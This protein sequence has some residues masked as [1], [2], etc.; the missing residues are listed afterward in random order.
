MAPDTV[1]RL[2]PLPRLPRL[3]LLALLALLVPFG[4]SRARAQAP[5]DTVLLGIWGSDDSYGPRA[6]GTLTVAH[7][8]AGWRA[9]IAG[10]AATPRVERDSTWIT[11]P[12]S[13][14]AF[15]GRIGPG[16]GAL[17]GLW[18]QPAGPVYDQAYASPLTLARAGGGLW[19]GPVTPL[20]QRFSLTLLVTRQA[21]GTLLGSFHNPDANS[22]GGAAAFRLTHDG[23]TVR[24]SDTAHARDGGPPALVASYDSAHRQLVL[25]WPDIGR[26]I[27]LTRRGAGDAVG[28][29]P[30]TPSLAASGYRAPLAL[31]DGWPVARGRDVGLDEGRLASLVQQIAHG[32]P[33]LDTTSL[34]HSVLVE[35]H[36]TLVLEEY[37]FGFD[38]D[39]THD[40]RSAGKTFASVLVGAARLHGVRVG[41]ETPVYPTFRSDGPVANADPRK[42]RI[43]LAQLLTHSTGLA[44]DDNGEPQP[45]NEDQMQG[46]RAQPDW[47]RY[48]LDLPMRHDPGTTYAYCSGTMNLVGGVVANLTG[49]WLPDLFDRWVAQPLGIRQ[50]HLNLMPTG[51][52]YFGGG[53]Q[54]R[55]RDFLKLG[56]V[57]RD[58]GT[59]RGR[60]IVTRGW[61]DTSTARQI[62]TSQGGADGYAWHLNT[63]HAAGRAYREYEANGNGGQFL[64]VLPDLDLAVVFTGGDYGRYRIWRRWRDD[65]VPTF[66]IPAV[67][68]AAPRGA[69]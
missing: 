1:R 32:D 44:C 21:D 7:G 36:G 62:T 65:L 64:I 20:D 9:E 46:Q 47:Y 68:G 38:A 37:F 59:W 58:G 29:Y 8:P 14:G 27:V 4:S 26:P 53:I 19:R 52:A 41:P 34:I 40:L 39:R 11:L 35:R 60:R 23:S 10:F 3:P 57:Y 17:A 63:L 67:V 69:R 16:G 66:I 56:A 30:R 2:A 6:R 12:D 48:T 28:L 22:R 31:P 5:A 54:L 13:Q 24:F 51:Q 25:P 43:T 50:Y 45:G 55:P 15:R 33:T 61:I 42:A 18:V 49:G